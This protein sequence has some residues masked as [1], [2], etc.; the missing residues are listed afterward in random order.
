MKKSRAEWAEMLIVDLYR[1]QYIQT[2]WNAY[3]EKN[4]QEGWVLKSGIW[5]PWFFNMRP[6][7]NSPEL[8]TNICQA[9]ADM[10]VASP[11][12]DVLIGVEMAGIHLVGG[13]S[14][15][16]FLNHDYSQ[17]IG[18][19]RPLPK[20]TRK[21]LETMEYLQELE[22]VAGYGEKSFVEARFREG[23]S[24]GV[25]DDMA[26]DIGSKL[27][28]RQIILWTSKQKAVGL[29]CNRIFYFL[30]RGIGNKQKGL[31][32]AAESKQGLF[33]EPLS[34]D[35][36]VEF[37]HHLHLLKQVMKPE[38]YKIIADFQKDVTQFQDKDVQKE[39]LALAN[40]V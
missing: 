7:G 2:V 6:S 13:T 22:E 25:Y 9:M 5:A 28:A 40:K 24:V 10:I 11:P 23:D 26:T 35:Y 3:E 27:I 16:L 39:V 1:E 4:R 19:T 18:F 12:V 30:N 21:P 14:V 33:P 38:E 34:V 32:F 36:V 37:D 29:K 20:K 8:F 15:A 17:R 31:D